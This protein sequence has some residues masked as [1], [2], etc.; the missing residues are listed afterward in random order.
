MIICKYGSPTITGI[1][2]PGSIQ[3]WL[4]SNNFLQIAAYRKLQWWYPSTHIASQNSTYLLSDQV[5]NAHL[6]V[7]TSTEQRH[8]WRISS[9]E[10]GRQD[11][12]VDGK[13]TQ[14]M[15]RPRKGLHLH[16]S[17]GVCTS[18]SSEFLSFPQWFGCNQPN[19]EVAKGSQPPIWAHQNVMIFSKLQKCSKYQRHEPT[20]LVRVDPAKELT[21]KAVWVHKAGPVTR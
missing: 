2:R 19:H 11:V 14:S 4:T 20:G 13:M 10:F 18:L 12:R 17:V 8:I 16:L 5:Q 7:F 6:L 3:N 15:S 1:L 9:L 21:N